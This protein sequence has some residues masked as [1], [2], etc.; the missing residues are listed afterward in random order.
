[1]HW[2]HS[3]Q[4]RST[5]GIL[6]PKTRTTR[7]T[8]RHHGHHGHHGHTHRHG[9]GLSTAGATTTTARRSPGTGLFHRRV[10]TPRT[11]VRTTRTTTRRTG[12]GGGLFGTRHH[13]TKRSHVLPVATTTRRKPTVG[14]RI[15][16][17][18]HKIKGSITGQPREKAIGDR[19]M[20][21]TTRRRRW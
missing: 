20:H 16:G 10:H 21:G 6:S 12:G 19:R 18:F 17:A 13:H 4:T 7:T 1:M 14:D 3:T 2:H 8:H 15:S 11:K 5:G 9:L